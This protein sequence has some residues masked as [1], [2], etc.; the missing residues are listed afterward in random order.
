MA[1]VFTKGGVAL[2]TGGAS[3]IGLAIA[4]K[5][6]GYGMRVIIADKSAE[7]LAAARQSLGD[8]ATALEMDVSRKEDWDLVKSRIES[9]FGGR[10]IL[11]SALPSQCKAAHPANNSP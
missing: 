4:R 11:R 3:G 6:H 5:C 1:Q 9:D 8:G 2:I 7:S 10:N